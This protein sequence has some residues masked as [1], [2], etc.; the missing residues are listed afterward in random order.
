MTIRKAEQ[1]DI[2]QI[3][4][5]LFQVNNVHAEGRPDLF[6]KDCKKYTSEEL[7]AIL[8]EDSRPIFTAL[9]GDDLLGYA[10]CILQ[11]TEG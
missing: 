11:K 2:P 5:L 7:E 6:K 1:K 3:E 9:D 10:F 4:K 8:Q